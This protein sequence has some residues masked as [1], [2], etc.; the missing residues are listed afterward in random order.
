[1]PKNKIPD[2]S[3][4]TPNQ[5]FDYIALERRLITPVNQ[6]SNSLILINIIYNAFEIIKIMK[7][8]AY[9]PGRR[10]GHPCKSANYPCM[11]VWMPK[12]KINADQLN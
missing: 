4:A 3:G 10:T 6:S 1:M 9:I 2:S 8:S 12:K 7:L 11:N 5:T